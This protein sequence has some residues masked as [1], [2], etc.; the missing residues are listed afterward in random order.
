MRLIRSRNNGERVF[1]QDNVPAASHLTSKKKFQI[2][3]FHLL[4]KKR[5]DWQDMMDVKIDFL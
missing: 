4:R 2:L 1:F 5:V 3:S